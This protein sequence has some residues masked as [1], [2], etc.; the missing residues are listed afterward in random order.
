MHTKHETQQSAPTIHA[1]ANSPSTDRRDS[2]KRLKNANTPFT[3]FHNPK[4][5]FIIRKKCND[6]IYN[7]INF[8]IK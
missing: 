4:C 8:P 2:V 7:P 3:L 5:K 6:L 1:R